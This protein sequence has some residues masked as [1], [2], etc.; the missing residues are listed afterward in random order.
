MKSINT[1][2]HLFF[3]MRYINYM[4]SLLVTFIQPINNRL[5]K[6]ILG[7][8]KLMARKEI[9]VVN[10]NFFC[11]FFFLSIPTSLPVPIPTPTSPL[12]SHSSK[13]DT[14]GKFVWFVDT[15]LKASDFIR[16]LTQVYHIVVDLFLY[17]L[18]ISIVHHANNSSNFIISCLR[19]SPGKFSFPVTASLGF[20]WFPKNS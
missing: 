2:W 6:Q 13:F 5:C 20:F 14:G 10:Q 16:F 12:T 7:E 9:F 18:V 3:I 1:N 17:V 15:K 19:Y 8:A 11:F 4:T